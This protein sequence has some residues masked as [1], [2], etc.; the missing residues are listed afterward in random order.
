MASSTPTTRRVLS[1]LNV[2]TPTGRGAVQPTSKL[3]AASPTKPQKVGE[4]SLQTEL[5]GDVSAAICKEARLGSKKRDA[6]VPMDAPQSPSKRRKT[7]L[8]PKAA[9]E[10]VPQISP[11]GESR[12]GSIDDGRGLQSSPSRVRS[13]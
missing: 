10:E 8:T 7:V 4:V 9:R 1:D 12:E 6:D 11:H 5:K 3:G 2:N 13:L